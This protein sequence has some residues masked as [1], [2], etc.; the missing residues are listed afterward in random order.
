MQNIHP[1]KFQSINEEMIRKA[2][3][4]TKGD[5]GPSGMNDGGW[6]AILPSNNFGTSSSDLCKL[7]AHVVRKL[8]TDLVETH[9]IET[10]LSCC[11]TPLDK[12]LELQPTGVG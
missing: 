2:A 12:N 5:S 7:F 10:F 1:V 6:R 3:I 11:L 8:C 9:T 4:R